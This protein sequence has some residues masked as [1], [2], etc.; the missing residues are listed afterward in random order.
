MYKIT[1]NGVALDP[2]LY[3]IDKVNKTF[4]SKEN[5]LVL[6]FTGKSNWIFRIGDHCTI[7][8]Y[9]DCTIT[10]GDHCNIDAESNCNITTGNRCNIDTC[11]DCNIATGDQA[12]VVTCGDSTITSGKNCVVIRHVTS[13]IIRLVPRQTIRLNGYGVKGYTIVEPI[14][15]IVFE[16]KKYNKKEVTDFLKNLKPIN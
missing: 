7:D 8:T 15:T 2:E 11:S 6:D 10:V 5:N 4:T 14:E 1:K 13:E 16:G 3:T 9:S 12:V